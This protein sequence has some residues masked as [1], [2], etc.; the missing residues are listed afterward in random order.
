MYDVN[1]DGKISNGELYAVLKMMVGNNLTPV[2]LQQVVDK[3]I[4]QAD[5]DGD[6]LVSFEEF[7][8]M[9]GDSVAIS[10]KLT[11]DFKAKK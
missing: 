9:V 3:S 7:C 1:N 6:G 8:A 2:Q 4:L 5:K 10:E 11:L